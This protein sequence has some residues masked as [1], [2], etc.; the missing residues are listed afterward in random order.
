[1]LPCAFASAVASSPICSLVSIGPTLSAGSRPTRHVLHAVV[2]C[3]KDLLGSD[4]ENL[5]PHLAGLA[6]DGRDRALVAVHGD[7]ARID[8]PPPVHDVRA[9]GAGYPLLRE[10][11]RE[12]VV[13]HLRPTVE[14]ALIV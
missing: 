10:D 13:R 14:H 12:H 3:G 11:L 8:A 6:D 2:G 4:R 7:D 5:L 9:I 1:M